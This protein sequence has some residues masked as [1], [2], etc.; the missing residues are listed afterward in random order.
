MNTLSK[1]ASSL[2]PETL[3][4]TLTHLGVL[5]ISG[6]DGRKFLQGQTT[7]DMA[8]L[9]PTAGLYGAICNIKGRIISNFFVI[10]ENEDMLLVMDKA[11]VEKTLPHLKKYAVFFKT[12]L[13]DAS[14]TYSIQASIE[15]TGQ[16]AP[17]KLAETIEA[18]A[19]S[20]AVKLVISEF[21][22]RITWTLQQHQATTDSN[23]DLAALLTLLTARPLI[24]A[25]Q[26]EEVLPQWL[27]MQRT[28]GISFTKG[29][30]TGQEIVAR[31]QYRGKSKKQL[32]LFSYQGPLSEESAVVD[33]EG[34]ALGQVLQSATYQGQ[35]VV[36]VVLNIE[37]EE[38]ASFLLGEL[39]LTWLPLPYQLEKSE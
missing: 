30:Y 34:K 10:Q 2:L 25:E 27:N 20:N 37:P 21:P 33:A 11:L 16:E 14:D 8:K 32:A 6:A 23:S 19:S 13:E 9:S 39:P 35:S 36:Q 26:S 38:S 3:H 7:C 31:M 12:T 15:A 17:T 1:L 24:N 5:R 4:S 22:T 29:C 28:G 18:Q